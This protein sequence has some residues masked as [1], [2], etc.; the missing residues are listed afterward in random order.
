MVPTAFQLEA[1]RNTFMHCRSSA[2]ILVIKIVQNITR[3]AVLLWTAS[4]DG[5]RYW[6]RLPREAVESLSLEV[7][8]KCVDVAL[9]DIVY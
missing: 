8:K 5:V 2:W 1:Q 7:L 6:N 3:E 4:R 9:R